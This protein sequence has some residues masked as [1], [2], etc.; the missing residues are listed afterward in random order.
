M[1]IINKLQITY[2]NKTVVKI[3]WVLKS[4]GFPKLCKIFRFL[5]KNNNFSDFSPDFE[6]FRFFI[7]L[8]TSQRLW[9]D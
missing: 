7:N 4:L 8:Q 2:F 1:Y 5:N 9:A 6:F 3:C